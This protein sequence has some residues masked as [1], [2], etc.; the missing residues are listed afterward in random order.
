MRPAPVC[1]DHHRGCCCCCVGWFTPLWRLSRLKR[2]PGPHPTLGFLV[3]HSPSQPRHIPLPHAQ[4]HTHARY[5]RGPC[6]MSL[7]SRRSLWVFHMRPVVRVAQRRPCI[8][9]RHQSQ[10][11]TR[12]G[13]VGA[14]PRVNERYS[15]SRTTGSCR[16]RPRDL[17]ALLDAPDLCLHAERVMYRMPEHRFALSC[18]LLQHDTYKFTYCMYLYK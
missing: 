11:R 16:A 6:A 12:R 8:P 18:A 1:I 9:K 17:R 3:P 7:P 13:A 14:D 4:V 5:C 15:P 10:A 2:P